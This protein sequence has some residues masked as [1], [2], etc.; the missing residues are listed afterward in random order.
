MT[1]DAI[2][3]ASFGGPDGPDDVMPF[4][5]RATAGKGVPRQRLEEVAGHYH[6]MGG[7]SPLN[8]QNRRLVQ[9]MR[10]ELDGR[11]LGTPV[12]W[13]SRN[14]RPLFA[15]A[16]RALHAGGHERVLA[17]ATSAYSSYSGCRQYREDLARALDEAGLAGR[18]DIRKA[19]PYGDRSG[20]SDGF[21]RGIVAALDGL[22]ELGIPGDQAHIVF[23]TH[24]IPDSMGLTSGPASRRAESRPG[25]YE[26]QHLDVASRVVDGVAST[27]RSVP[28]WSL[29]FQSRSGPAT[30]PWLGPDVNDALAELPA[31]GARA[32]IVVP[33]GFVS[34]HVEVAWDLDREA[35][36]T[37]ARL[38]LAFVRVATPGVDP[39]F[40]SALV[41]L[42]QAAVE[43][44][45]PEPAGEWSG[46]C[47]GACCPN[48]RAD[49]PV[50]AAWPTGV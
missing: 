43:G 37:A 26:R 8:A 24:S 4:L 3:L 33:I 16:L 46:L 35:A 41:D 19:C 7:V 42:V 32:A 20:F 36:Q 12:Y 34:D 1:V 21:A 45:V 47:A 39:A 27:G 17:V 31:R 6:A 48:A 2:L 9:A 44:R 40:V 13:G 11:G 5:E 29:A 23:V 18:L 25:V 49:R 22:V 30:V 14:S 10:E 38:G 28:A 15:D 50:I